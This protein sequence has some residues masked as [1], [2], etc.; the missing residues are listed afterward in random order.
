V[1]NYRRI[2][3]TVEPEQLRDYQLCLLRELGLAKYL[4]LNERLLGHREK[5]GKQGPHGVNKLH[6]RHKN[7]KTSNSKEFAQRHSAP[8]LSRGH[9]FISLVEVN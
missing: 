9:I 6:K 8:S 7:Q 5:T 2:Q 3:K 1:N 4:A